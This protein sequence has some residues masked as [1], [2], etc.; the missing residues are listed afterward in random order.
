MTKH[1]GLGLGLTH[2]HPSLYSHLVL[3]APCILIINIVQNVTLLPI[4]NKKKNFKYP[5][6][7]VYSQNLYCPQII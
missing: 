4:M 6:Y 1:A 2:N 5:L 3:T 7:S